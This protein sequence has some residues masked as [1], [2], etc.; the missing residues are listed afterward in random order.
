VCVCVSF[1]TV[2]GKRTFSSGGTISPLDVFEQFLFR[3]P[4][5]KASRYLNN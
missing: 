2:S 3:T 1:P 5:D 4:Q